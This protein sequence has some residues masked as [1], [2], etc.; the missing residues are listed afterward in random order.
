M[1]KT[2]WADIPA[3]MRHQ[4]LHFKD[5]RLVERIHACQRMLWYSELICLRSD[6]NILTVGGEG[7]DGLAVRAFEFTWLIAGSQNL[8]NSKPV[9]NTGRKDDDE[10]TPVSFS[11]G[12]HFA[13]S[14]DF[15]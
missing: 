15:L 2:L 6:V 11:V 9:I 7:S 8:E 3:A 4:I 5:A 13:E 10:R 14:E 1:L 12:R